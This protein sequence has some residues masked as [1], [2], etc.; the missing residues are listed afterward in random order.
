VRALASEYERQAAAAAA[1]AQPPP[2]AAAAGAGGAP[3]DG[4]LTVCVQMAADVR[5]KVR[6]APGDPMSKLFRTVQQHMLAKGVIREGQAVRFI[7]DGDV[8]RGGQTPEE[9][10]LEG[11]ELVE[12]QV[13]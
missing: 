3:A 5:L 10:G 13:S 12:V 6:I 7:F 11:E 4:K 9:L 1:A 8:L 2:A